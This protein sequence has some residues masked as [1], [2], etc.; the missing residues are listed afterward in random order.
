MLQVREYKQA[1]REGAKFQEG[2]IKWT[3]RNVTQWPLLC[4]FAGGVAGLF[5]VGGGTCH[6]AFDISGWNPGTCTAAMWLAM[7][8]QVAGIRNAHCKKTIKP[9]PATA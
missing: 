5:G 8:Q 3:P 4:I 2:D 1:R 7:P 9:R 6:A